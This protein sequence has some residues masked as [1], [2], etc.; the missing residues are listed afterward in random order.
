MTTV[1]ESPPVSHPPKLLSAE[2]VAERLDLPL[3]TVYEHARSN[4]IGGAIRIGRRL[5][6][7]PQK[8]EAWLNAG[9]Q[10]LPGGWKH[11]E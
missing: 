9:G 6:F 11:D 7:D 8:L 2:A 5:R 1:S 3:S 10:A 4:R